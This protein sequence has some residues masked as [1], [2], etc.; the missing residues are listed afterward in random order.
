MIPSSVNLMK[1][2]SINYEELS[3]LNND[4]PSFDFTSIPDEND[5]ESSLK[6]ILPLLNSI[7]PEY[8]RDDNDRDRMS[9][10]I[11]DFEGSYNY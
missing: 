2:E 7:L 6:K 9:I 4:H 5:V 3:K 8:P 10:P 11:V 1:C